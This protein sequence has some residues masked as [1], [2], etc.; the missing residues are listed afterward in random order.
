MILILQVPGVTEQGTA[1]GAYTQSLYACQ[2][3]LL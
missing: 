1:I 3:V 2:D